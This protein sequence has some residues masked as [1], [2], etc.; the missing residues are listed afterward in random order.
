MFLFD[1]VERD[2]LIKIDLIKF[3]LKF[4]ELLWREWLHDAVVRRLKHFLFFAAH[5][6]FCLSKIAH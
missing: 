3:K 4:C 5:P 6:V 2:D 1:V